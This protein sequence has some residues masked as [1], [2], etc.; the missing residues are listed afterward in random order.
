[1]LDLAAR[2]LLG[3]VFVSA[4]L[5]KIIA[6]AAFAK[7][8]YGYG[9]VP[10]ELINAVA[11][12]LPHVEMVAGTALAAGVLIRP[13][14][15]VLFGLLILFIS[16]TSINWIRGHVFD[17]GCFSV[18]G[19]TTHTTPAVILARDIALVLIVVFVGRFQ[20]RRQW[21]LPGNRS[22]RAG[23]TAGHRG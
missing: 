15:R 17:C 9:L 2:W 8:V 23:I 6:P 18:I 16:A 19:Q 4:A 12:V 22:G 1:V 5:P 11:I 13:A 21:V 7:I 20:G 10:P 3:V 14:V